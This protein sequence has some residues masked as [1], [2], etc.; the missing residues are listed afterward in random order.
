[1][2]TIFP[3]FLASVFFDMALG[4]GSATK[5]TGT[6]TRGWSCCKN[7]CSWSNKALVNSPVISCDNVDNL[8]NSPA[9][10][11]GCESGGGSFA[12][13]DLSPWAAS[14][15]LSYGFAGVNIAASNESAWCCSC[16][17]L[18]FTSGAVN[19]KQ[20]VVQ[21]VNTGS[22]L[23]NDQFDLAIPGGGQGNLQGCTKE[24]GGTTDLWGASYG[25]VA[26]REDCNALPDPLKA[27]C[28]W[29]FDW[30]RN[31]D[32][33]TVSWEKVTCPEAL[34]YV[35][36]CRR[37]DDPV[38]GKVTPTPTK[39]APIESGTVAQGSQCGGATYKG[40]TVCVS[41]T[42]CTYVDENHY[43]CLPDPASTRSTPTVTSSTPIPTIAQVWDQCGGNGWPG[44]YRCKDSQ[45][46]KFDDFYSQCQPYSSGGGQPVV[47]SKPQSSAPATYPWGGQWT[48]P[49]RTWPGQVPNQ[50]TSGKPTSANPPAA[51]GYAQLYDQC[52]GLTYT[53]TKNCAPGLKCVYSDQWYSQCQ[54]A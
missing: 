17:Q 6:T 3:A 21:V 12:C 34:S 41:G 31:T 53:G 13:S 51:T 2:K 23:G 4:A 16:Y 49:H 18:T 26:H 36:G 7:S 24:F 42:V 20:M 38:P 25:G 15:D 37:N 27:G 28:Y 44:P 35:S 48:R 9:R 45:C 39:S 33:P 46:V 43:Y 54:K 30:F 8:L 19:G 47:T 11:D 50:P 32:N 14:N 22:D 10:R 1:M 5:G 40:P 29:R 52:G